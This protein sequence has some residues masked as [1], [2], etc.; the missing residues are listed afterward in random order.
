MNEELTQVYHW[1]TSNKLTLNLKKS[2]YVIFRP[3]QKKLSFTPKLFIHNASTN[4]NSQLECKDSVKYLGV[5]IDHK[6][7][8]NNHINTILLKISRTVGLLSKLRHFCSP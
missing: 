6:V 8:W 3:Y 1:L 2:N 5:L 4:K 7:S